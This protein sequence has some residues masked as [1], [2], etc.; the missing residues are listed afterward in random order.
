MVITHRREADHLVPR[1]PS[2]RRKEVTSVLRTPAR[3]FEWGG[4]W[5]WAMSAPSGCS[6]GQQLP[7]MVWRPGS[8]Q[9]P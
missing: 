6:S 9:G 5:L 3:L 2:W 7:T 4:G 1:S 8:R